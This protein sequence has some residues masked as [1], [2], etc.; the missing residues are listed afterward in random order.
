MGIWESLKK[1]NTS[2]LMAASGNLV[3]AV[4]KGAA[5]AVSGS[6]AMYASAMHSVADTVNQGFVFAGSVLAEKKPTP[7]FPSGFGRVINMF[8][9]VAVIVVTIMAVETIEKGWEIIQHPKVSSD[10]WLNAGLLFASIVIDGLILVKAMKEIVKE[11]D[12]QKAPG[13]LVKKAL[14]NLKLASPPTRLVFYE[15]CVATLGAFLALLAVVLAPMT[16]IYALEG[17]AAI[18]I[19]CLLLFIA[20]KLGYEN[21]IGLIGVA[22]P[23]TVEDRVA[24]IIFADREVVDINKMRILQEGRS[25]HVEAYIELRKGLSLADADDIKFRIQS[26]LTADKDIT[27]ATLGILEDNDVRNWRAEEVHIEN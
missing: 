22:A 19:A 27:D 15:D 12:Q 13:S 25:Y 14:G 26:S 20:F 16:G 11:S 2:S 23:K 5:A 7:R 3:L 4:A 6:S 9:M 18:L 10:I 1:G 24:N 8:V 21:M 17:V